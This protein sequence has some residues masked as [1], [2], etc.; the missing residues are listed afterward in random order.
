MLNVLPPSTF[1][2]EVRPQAP[3]SAP[4]TSDWTTSLTVA[5]NFSAATVTPVSHFEPPTLTREPLDVGRLQQCLR[6]A[7]YDFTY[8]WPTSSQTRELDALT[9]WVYAER[10]WWAIEARMVPWSDL[11]KYRS[12]LQYARVRWINFWSAQGVEALLGTHP[13]VTLN[14]DPRD[15]DWDFLMDFGDTELA[16][17]H[18]TTCWPKGW[19][20]RVEDAIR[21]PEPLIR[22]LY[23][24]QRTT[25]RRYKVNNRFFVVLV[26]RDGLHW[27]LKSE[28]STI[29]LYLRAWLQEPR[30]HLL[31]LPDGEW[32]YA[33]AVIVRD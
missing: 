5:P 23:A 29:R 33:A 10:R 11:P 3:K 24:N 16:F 27:M 8:D 13:A 9:N 6:A 30:T 26:A 1:E 2:S 7:L 21:D 20:G 4:E 17:D 14:P 22:W 18:K 19:D 32:V 25:S 15:P 31:Q 28:M 12:L